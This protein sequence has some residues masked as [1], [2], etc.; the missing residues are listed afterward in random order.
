MP[1]KRLLIFILAIG[2]LAAGAAQTIALTSGGKTHAQVAEGDNPP[3][4][5]GDKPPKHDD[6]DCDDD[7]KNHG[8]DMDNNAAGQQY[9]DDDD[10]DCVKPPDEH[11]PGDDDKPG[12]GDDDKKSHPG[13]SPNGQASSTQLPKGPVTCTSRRRFPLH[14]WFGAGRVRGGS[15][16]VNGKSAHVVKSGRQ[17]HAMVDLRSLNRGVYTVTVTVR[18]A[19]GRSVSFVRRYRTCTVRRA[20]A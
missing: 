19:S 8:D 13:Q 12:K 3:K 20:A 7:D 5:E 16:T 2:L 4:D 18:F 17:S 11:K 6:G 14:L 1:L 10:K 15:V 9:D